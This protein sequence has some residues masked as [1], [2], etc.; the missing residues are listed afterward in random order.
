MMNETMPFTVSSF[1]TFLKQKKFMAVKCNDC[2]T[3][4]LPPKPM[5]TNCL[6][7]NLKWIKVN[8]AGKLLSYT[9]I[10]VAPEQFQSMAPYCVGIVDFEDG[11]RLPGM[12][13]DMSP[14]KIK[15]GMKLKIDTISIDSS[16]WPPWGRYCF[17][18]V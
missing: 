8:D 10:H 11:L 6:S 13:C 14:E 18:P 1:Y 7:T 15:I 4:I 5:C 9:V 17:R 16:Q 2:K 3:K 12:I